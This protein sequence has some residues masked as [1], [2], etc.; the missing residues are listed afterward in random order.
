MLYILNDRPAITNRLFLILTI[1]ITAV[2]R[3]VGRDELTP[4]T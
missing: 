3:G 2:L 4:D 1:P